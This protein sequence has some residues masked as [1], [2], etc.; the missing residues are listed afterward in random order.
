MSTDKPQ[1][2]EDAENWDFSTAETRPPVK[3]A[4]A[5]VSVGFGRE[6]Y[7]RVATCAENTGVR[8][9]EFIREAA[10][11]RAFRQM[12]LATLSSYSYSPAWVFLTHRPSVTTRP[13]VPTHLLEIAFQNVT[14]P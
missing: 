7:E 4:R 6:D 14:S 10:L 11:E 13:S 9:S 3:A 5:V 1:G 12:A 2:L 8:I